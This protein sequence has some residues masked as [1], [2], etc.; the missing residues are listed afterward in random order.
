MR[1]RIWIQPASHMNVSCC[2]CKYVTNESCKLST[3][4]KRNVLRRNE[5]CPTHQVSTLEATIAL[6]HAEA[7]TSQEALNM[8]DQ[9][10]LQTHH[11]IQTLKL[12]VRLLKFDS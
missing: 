2:T 1:I 8:L 10:Q 4:E 6:L 3:C 12:Q 5:S 9:S 11:T 7:R